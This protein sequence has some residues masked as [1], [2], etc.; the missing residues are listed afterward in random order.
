MKRL[1]RLFIGLF[2]LCILIFFL[3]CNNL[4]LANNETVSYYSELKKA[5]KEKGYKPRLLVISTKR[6]A[7]HNNI[8][9]KFSG[10]ASG[11]K[12]LKGDAI[13]F[14]V[15][16]I[17]DDGMR[18]SNDVDIVTNILETK[19]MK[20]KGGIGTYKNEGSFVNRQMIHIDCRKEKARWAR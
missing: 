4:A 8:Q 14:L 10:A 17:N 16:D 13:D 7:F 1:S 12:H 9:V 3:Y 20:E 19:I 5:I 2:L 18:N 11:S 6:F 15:F